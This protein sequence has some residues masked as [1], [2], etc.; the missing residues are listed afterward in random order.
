MSPWRAMTPPPTDPRG[1]RGV[2]E[3]GEAT[4]NSTADP[5]LY[6]CALR[7]PR[8]AAYTTGP[9]TQRTPHNT[10]TTV[11]PVKATRALFIIL[12]MWSFRHCVLSHISM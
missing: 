7:M 11:E 9:S 1:S 5:V 8:P 4:D 10:I 6:R 12:I 2:R 3:E